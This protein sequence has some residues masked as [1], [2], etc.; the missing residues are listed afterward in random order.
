MFILRFGIWVNRD[1]IGFAFKKCSCLN[2]Y[3]LLFQGFHVNILKKSLI[4]D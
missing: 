2:F 1:S 4:V 3:E